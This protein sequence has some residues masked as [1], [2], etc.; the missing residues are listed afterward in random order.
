MASCGIF[1]LL[2]LVLASGADAHVALQ[3]RV[4]G[5]PSLRAS[6]QRH[7]VAAEREG[8]LGFAQL[9]VHDQRAHES[10]GQQLGHELEKGAAELE[11]SA[12][13]F[14]D[15]LEAED[16]AAL[17]GRK[18]GLSCVS[19]GVVLV[20]SVLLSVIFQ[21]EYVSQRAA[22]MFM[23]LLTGLI[24][25]WLF[26]QGLFQKW[27]SGARLGF[28]CTF[29]CWYALA[30]LTILLVG[31]CC[32]TCWVGL[33][34]TAKV[35]E[36][37]AL[38]HIKNRAAK[39]IREEFDKK[40]TGLSGPRRSFY[41]SEAFKDKC[42]RL[43]DKA[44]A[45][46][47]GTLTLQELYGVTSEAFGGDIPEDVLPIF[48]KAFDDNANSEIEKGEF[49]EMCKFFSMSCLPEKFENRTIAQHFETLSLGEEASMSDVKKQYRR[50]AMIYHPDKRKDD[51][52]EDVVRA[53]MQEINDAYEALTRH[54]AVANAVA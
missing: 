5:S 14:T 33:V 35:I 13:R 23:S 50:L 10:V 9:E 36:P 32:F 11:S 29:L 41:T 22:N 37:I 27:W 54:F 40:E 17:L 2:A 46:R 34:V 51:V 20:L 31:M 18:I 39:L 45:D 52:S 30:Q 8:N 12:R 26:Y 42:D 1:C 53:D 47:S 44:D 28:W 25:G 38:E 43:F 7:V 3:E 19:L 16:S 49:M 15:G 21:P 24:I 48:Q 6:A 4:Q